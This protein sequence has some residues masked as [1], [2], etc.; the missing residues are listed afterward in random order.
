MDNVKVR[1][2]LAQTGEAEEKIRLCLE[3]MALSL[4]GEGTPHFREFWQI[5]QL[6]LPYFKEAITPKMRSLL[7]AKYI[8]LSKEAKRLKE[9]LDEESSFTV[10]Q[11]ELA[12]Q[13]IERDLQVKQAL[14]EQAG[15]EL[16][17]DGVISIKGK[18]EVYR[19]WQKQMA[20]LSQLCL[21]INGL[22]KEVLNTEMRVRIKNQILA[23]LSSCA[24]E[25]FPARRALIQEISSSFSSDIKQ[26]VGDPEL[27]A[28]PEPELREELKKLQ[29]LAQQ[30]TLSAATFGQIRE[31][32][33][34]CWEQLKPRRVVS[35]PKKEHVPDP[36]A[37]VVQKIEGV[38][39]NREQMSEEELAHIHRE[40]KTELDAFS[41]LDQQMLLCYLQPLEEELHRKKIESFTRL[42]ESEQLEMILIQHEARRQEIKKQIEGYR[43][44]LGGSNLDFEKAMLYRE[45]IEKEKNGLEKLE[46]EIEAI[47]EKI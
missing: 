25:V 18:E 3:A 11:I 39:K 13:A 23:R 37:V 17:L 44:I 27:L 35:K 32:L 7:W 10:E 46:E 6:C 31:A 45:M 15:V 1:E 38:V 20:V 30:L 21:K 40:L 16:S 42:P 47:E 36:K 5:K 14:F 34:V 4:S 33:S 28:L 26:F 8:E 19:N 29:H 24:D 41:S 43:K 2:K 9:I 22:R 12:V